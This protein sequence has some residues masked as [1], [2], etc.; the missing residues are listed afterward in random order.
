M[1]LTGR[2]L[3]KSHRIHVGGNRKD[4]WN[5]VRDGR[6][7]SRYRIWVGSL[8]ELGHRSR[9]A[10]CVLAFLE[11]TLVFLSRTSYPYADVFCISCLDVRRAFGIRPRAG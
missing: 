1:V 9:P 5:R 10:A 11:T 7:G 3:G 8:T 6:Q 2:R 4:I